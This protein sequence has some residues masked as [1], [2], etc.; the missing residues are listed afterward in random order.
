MTVFLII[1]SILL[2]ASSIWCLF[3]RQVLA[4]ALSYLALVALSFVRQNGY[5][6]I[7]VNGVMLTGWLCMT[8]A[9]MF[10]VILQ[11]E[12]VRRQIRGMWF[13]TAGAL[14][15]LAVGLVGYSVTSS[16]GMRYA[17]MIL[18]VVAGIVLGFLFYTGTPA[19]RPVRPGSGYFLKL[20][21]AKGFPTAITIMQLG[22]ALVLLLAVKNVNGL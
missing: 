19:G 6:V 12:E 14:V 17:W 20:L 4:P 1:L 11:P 16:I 7:P 22:V 9:V 3:G 21:L 13:M 5:A 8:L 2:W 18:A 15:G 10:V